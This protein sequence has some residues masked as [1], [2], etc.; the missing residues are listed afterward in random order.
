MQLDEARSPLTL[1]AAE[2]FSGWHHLT[3]DLQILVQRQLYHLLEL[4]KLSEGVRSVLVDIVGRRGE[5][6]GV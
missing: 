3:E 2:L 4:P 1:S 5:G 6:R